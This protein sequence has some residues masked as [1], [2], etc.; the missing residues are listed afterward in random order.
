[1][2]GEDKLVDTALR[3]VE[4]I[5]RLDLAGLV[6]L[7]PDDHL[8]VD[9]EGDRD[10]G[11]AAMCPGWAG[12]MR[13]WP[14]Y[15]IHVGEIYVVGDEVILLGR[16]TGSHLELPRLQEFRDEPVIWVAKIRDGL[17]AEWRLYYVT[18]DNR[19]TLGMTEATRVA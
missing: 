16:T 19:A 3:F 5:N 12:Y 13:H 2:A 18:D 11:R 15:M 10:E 9:L 17:V 4:H 1:M 7:M 6:G 14:E 8:F